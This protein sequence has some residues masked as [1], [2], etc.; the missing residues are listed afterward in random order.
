MSKICKCRSHTKKKNTYFYINIHRTDA[1]IL[2]ILMCAYILH[3]L[4]II[5]LRSKSPWWLD[6]VRCWYFVTNIVRLRG[7]EMEPDFFFFGVIYIKFSHRQ[8]DTDFSKTKSSS[9]QI[10]SAIIIDA[11]H[12]NLMCHQ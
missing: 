8:R 4:T 6:A 7:A 3:F 5:Y 1:D 10:C 2:F 9:K 12:T 11:K